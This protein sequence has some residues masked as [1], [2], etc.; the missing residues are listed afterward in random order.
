M[1]LRKVVSQD[2]S[3]GIGHGII[4]DSL[5]SL[6]STKGGEVYY[7]GNLREKTGDLIN[8]QFPILIRMEGVVSSLPLG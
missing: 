5:H 1:L 8:V 7:R 6:G 2:T 3:G 4:A